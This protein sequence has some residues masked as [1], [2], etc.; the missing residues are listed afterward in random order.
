M[1]RGLYSE[2]GVYGISFFLGHRVK[3]K[4]RLYSLYTL[5]ICIWYS[6]SW[7]CERGHLEEICLH[8]GNAARTLF[9]PFFFFNFFYSFFLSTVVVRVYTF[10]SFSF[11]ISL[12]HPFPLALF[13]LTANSSILFRLYKPRVLQPTFSLWNDV[14]VCVCVYL[15]FFSFIRTVAPSFLVFFFFPA[16]ANLFPLFC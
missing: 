5:Y 2:S 15:F 8:S 12:Y 6:F 11:R 3:R 1:R 16:T 13:S 14:S 7:V 10:A 9:K 4:R